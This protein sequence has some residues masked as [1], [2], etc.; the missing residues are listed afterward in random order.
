MIDNL[1]VKY[2]IPFLIPEQY[3]DA[4]SYQELLYSILN[5]V[6]NCIDVVNKL[7]DNV[8]EE[9]NKQLSAMLSDGT[10]ADL[11][12]DTI[13][14]EL[15]N[16]IN[17]LTEK[18]TNNTKAITK[19][20]NDISA[21]QSST[22][23]A[24]TKNSNDISALQT[25]L[26][27]ATENIE[28]NTSDINNVKSKQTATLSA[29]AGCA[30]QSQ[31]LNKINNIAICSFIV[32]TSNQ[33]TA[34]TTFATIPTNFRPK[35]SIYFVMAKAGSTECINGQAGTDGAIKSPNTN[36]APNTYYNAQIVYTTI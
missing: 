19:N 2:N 13:F 32:V 5:S 36:L 27:S 35:S 12:N 22:T 15:N 1:N 3:N 7:P 14:N 9:V 23:A 28:Q 20:S 33:V 25:S 17:N 31:S 8:R 10:I 18:T 4:M 21:L 16:K 24:I 6:N 11:I 30:I 29:S 34:N 26:S